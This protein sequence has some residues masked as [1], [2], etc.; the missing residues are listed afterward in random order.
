M[1]FPTYSAIVLEL[2]GHV[3]Q[4]TLNRPERLNALND[5]L[6]DELDAAFDYLA[7]VEHRA[8]VIKGA[9]RAFSAG[10]DAGSDSK[11]IGYADERSAVE[12]RDRQLRNIEIFTKIWRHPLP[13]ITQVHGY[14]MA[15]GTQLCI[16]SDITIVAE[17]AVIAASPALPI[18]G[19]FISPIWATLVGPKRAK[20]MSFDAGHRIDGRT[21]AQWGWA[22]EAV[23]SDQLDE[24][25]RD[26]AVSISRTP[27]SILKLKK[28]AVNR[29]AEL[30][31]LIAISRMGAE[32]DALLH[33][34]PEIQKLQA[35]IKERGLKGAISH[36]NEVGL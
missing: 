32:T 12:D 8:V 35:S 28:E 15:G 27:A 23:P 9:G 7:G 26:L 22:T 4:I 16:F 24:Y 36:F 18:G 20:L 30:Q 17:D 14:C 3:A 25:V 21:A 10:Y 5:K 11:E 33:L 1:T 6:L 29:V 34:T 31:G 13:V 2:E 19:G